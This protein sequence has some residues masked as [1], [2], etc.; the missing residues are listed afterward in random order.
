MTKEELAK[1]IIEWEIEAGESFTDYFMHDRVKNLSW[2]FW[3]LGKGFTEHALVIIRKMEKDGADAYQEQETLYEI[4]PEYDENENYSNDAH[5]RNVMVWSE[6]LLST[7]TYTKR[8][9]EFLQE[10][11]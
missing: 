8:I 6:F 1:K 7:D 3:L 2:A 10:N 11:E 9:E 4:Y 5:E